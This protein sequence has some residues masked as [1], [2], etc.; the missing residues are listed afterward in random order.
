MAG[1]QVLVACA[2]FDACAHGV[3]IVRVDVAVGQRDLRAGP[4]DIEA[5]ALPE[6]WRSLSERARKVCFHIGAL[7]R[8]R[9]W[10]GAWKSARP[11]A[12]V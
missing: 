8:G 7:N 9:G 2:G 12:H 4:R 10:D 3:G 6:E 5:A 11:C 1:A